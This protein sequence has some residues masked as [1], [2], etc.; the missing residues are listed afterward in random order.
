MATDPIRVALADYGVKHNIIRCLVKR[1]CVRSNA[2]PYDASMEEILAFSPDGV[3]LSN[4][5]GDPQ[6]CVK[7]IEELKRL[8]NHGPPEFSAS[9][10]ATS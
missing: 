10:S 3:M 2:C 8:Y 9:A 7:S 5:P 4:G 1:G 6:A